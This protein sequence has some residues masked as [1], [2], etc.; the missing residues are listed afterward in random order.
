MNKVKQITLRSLRC[1]S[2]G[3]KPDKAKFI[4]A[5]LKPIWRLCCYHCNKSAQSSNPISAY[6]LW[7]ELQLEGWQMNKNEMITIELTRHQLLWRFYYG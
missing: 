5:D 6:R 4:T 3:R 2:C 7:N 1:S